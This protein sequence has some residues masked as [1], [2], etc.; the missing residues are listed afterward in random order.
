VNG[1]PFLEKNVT[2]GSTELVHPLPANDFVDAMTIF[3]GPVVLGCGEK[4]FADSWRCPCRPFRA[5]GNTEGVALSGVLTLVSL[6]I[7]RLA[8]LSQA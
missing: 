6:P 7:A 1:R 4:L 8:V 3:T 5:S 2:Q